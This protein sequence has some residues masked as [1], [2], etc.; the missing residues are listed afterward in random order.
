M[1][2]LQEYWKNMDRL[3]L[4]TNV[5]IDVLRRRT[6][7]WQEAMMAL[8]LAKEGQV[9]ASITALSLSDISYVLRKGGADEMLSF[10]TELR[11][12]IDVASLGKEEVDRALADPLADFEDTLQW[13]AATSWKATHLITRNEK[14]FPKGGALKVMSPMTYLQSRGS[15]L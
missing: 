12:C 13:V 5:L 3:F 4:D 15:I 1:S 11:L 9:I 8:S 14:D 7:F 10:F 6:G 2:D